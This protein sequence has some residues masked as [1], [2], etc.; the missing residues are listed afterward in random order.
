MLRHITTLALLV[1][2]TSMTGCA[3]FK[4]NHQLDPV[5][6]EAWVAKDMP[7]PEGFKLDRSQSWV[8]NRTHYRQPLPQP[9]GLA[10]RARADKTPRLQRGSLRP[11]LPGPLR[12]ISKPH[13]EAIPRW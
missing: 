12:D 6:V 11:E 10:Q 3:Y 7:V 9:S 8:H 13:T 2:M 5:P 4:T 1:A